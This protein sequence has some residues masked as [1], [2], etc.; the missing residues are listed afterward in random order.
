MENEK[1]NENNTDINRVLVVP[2]IRGISN[3]IKRIVKNCMDV[4]FT[5]LK[6]LNSL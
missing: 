3:R 1:T 4:R 5:I 6:K 2:Y